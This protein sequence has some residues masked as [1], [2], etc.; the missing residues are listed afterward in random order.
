MVEF[1]FETFKYCKLINISMLLFS[2]GIGITNKFYKIINI[3]NDN[4]HYDLCNIHSVSFIDI[5]WVPTAYSIDLS[6]YFTTIILIC[7]IRFTAET[8]KLV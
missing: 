1:G 4:L 8:G 5:R 7:T 6:R 2:R 3:H